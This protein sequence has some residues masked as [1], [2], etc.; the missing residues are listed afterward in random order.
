MKKLLI[1]VTASALFACNSN[2]Q[3]VSGENSQATNSEH[4]A[5]SDPSKLTTIEWIEGTDKSLGK[6]NEGPEV[7][8]TYRFKNSGTNPLVINQVQPGCGC[9]VAETPKEPIA[10]GAE[11]VIKARFASNGQP[12]FRKK[13]IT[14]YANVVSNPI[15]LTFS[16]D[17]TP[18]AQQQ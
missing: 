16:V 7:D 4:T 14:V 2:D 17:V 15:T 12:G 3:K 5:K 1:L 8:I 9:T 6:M 18:K 10:P 11:G 13:N